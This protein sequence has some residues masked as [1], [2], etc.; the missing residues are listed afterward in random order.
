MFQLL[1]GGGQL[2]CKLFILINSYAYLKVLIKNTPEI[3]KV[4]HHSELVKINLKK[5]FIVF[6]DS[7]G[8]SLV[9]RMPVLLCMGSNI[10]E[11]KIW[12]R[13]DGYHHHHRRDRG[14]C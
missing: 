10:K 13:E 5:Y 3:Q 11:E 6:F 9:V 2:H 8:R 12:C 7:V 14:V 4:L 1:S